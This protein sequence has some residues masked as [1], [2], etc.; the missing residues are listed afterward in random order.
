MTTTADD[1]KLGLLVWDTL[2]DLRTGY[3]EAD[4]PALREAANALLYA[5]NRRE[6]LREAVHLAHVVLEWLSGMFPDSLDRLKRAS[7]IYE[8]ARIK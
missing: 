7:R 5:E 4:K 2:S 8:E 6:A 3:A 1:G